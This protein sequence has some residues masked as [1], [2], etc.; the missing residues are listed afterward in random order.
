MLMRSIPGLVPLLLAFTGAAIA[1]SAPREGRDA[2]GSWQAD[3]PGT[4]RLRTQ[5]DTHSIGLS[6]T[7]ATSAAN[8]CHS[9][10]AIGEALSVRFHCP[11][12]HPGTRA[13]S[14]EIQGLC[15]LGPEQER[16]DGLA[17]PGAAERQ[18]LRTMLRA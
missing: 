18:R 12:R 4:I 3:K 13:M 9:R 16:G 10:A 14:E 5:T 11:V 17:R 8:G 6:V 7:Y 1:Q 15:V 2:F